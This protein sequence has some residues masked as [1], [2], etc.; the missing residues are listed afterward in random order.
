MGNAATIAGL[1]KM[2]LLRFPV[3]SVHAVSYCQCDTVSMRSHILKFEN[4][5]KFNHSILSNSPL[6]STVLLHPVVVISLLS[7]IKCLR[8]NNHSAI[9]RCTYGVSQ[10]LVRI[11]LL[12]VTGQTGPIRT[13]II[14]W[15][16]ITVIAAILY[17]NMLHPS[18]LKK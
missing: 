16:G 18:H 5:S 3:T 6:A 4:H 2:S 1:Y 9:T 13:A 15:V 17:L 14:I 10:Q 11:L 12:R 7:T 8:R